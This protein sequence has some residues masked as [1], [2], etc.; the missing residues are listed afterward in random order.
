MWYFDD[1][2]PPALKEAIKRAGPPILLSDVAVE[3]HG[4]RPL[5]IKRWCQENLK[6]FVWMDE[7]DV[8]DASYQFDYIYA[9]YIYMEKDRTWFTLRWGGIE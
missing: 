1:S 3:K 8:S 2:I 4:V 6:S 7:Q 9:F 5:D